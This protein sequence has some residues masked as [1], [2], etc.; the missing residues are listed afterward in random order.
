MRR[1]G[2]AR[3]WKAEKHSDRLLTVSYYLLLLLAVRDIKICAVFLLKQYSVCFLL[4]C[5]DY[6]QY[7]TRVFTL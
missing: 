7:S 5:G 4:F 2:I 6:Y 1:R 3:M